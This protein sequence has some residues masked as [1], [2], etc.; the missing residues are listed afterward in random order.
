MNTYQRSYFGTSNG[1]FRMTVDW[2]LQFYQALHKGAFCTHPFQDKAAILELKY[3]EGD[4]DLANQI[5]KYIPFRQT[6]SSK[7]VTGILKTRAV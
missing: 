7:Y 2:N 3:E 6:K 1:K 4:D 5:F